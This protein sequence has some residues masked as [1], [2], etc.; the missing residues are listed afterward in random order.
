MAG[1]S[2]MADND[3]HS[4]TSKKLSTRQEHQATLEGVWRGQSVLQIMGEGYSGKLQ[5]QEHWSSFL[6]GVGEH[7]WTSMSSWILNRHP[8]CKYA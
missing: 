1:R 8:S 5:K 6:N 4:W 7:F 2:G 3:L